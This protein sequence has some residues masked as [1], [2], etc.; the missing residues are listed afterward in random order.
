MSPAKV[1]K[2]HKIKSY[3]SVFFHKRC[4]NVFYFNSKKCFE[5]YFKPFVKWEKTLKQIFKETNIKFKMSYSLFIVEFET[6]F[7][8]SCDSLNCVVWHRWSAYTNHLFY[9][10]S[11]VTVHFNS[12]LF[13]I[14]WCV[15]VMSS[16]LCDLPSVLEL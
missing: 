1:S 6:G 10:R 7:G 4:T 3:Q 12:L 16:D 15:L 8:S 14:H 2:H 11:K 5:N 13:T 9:C